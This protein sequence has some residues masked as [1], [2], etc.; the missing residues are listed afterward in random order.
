MFYEELI[1]VDVWGP[2][3]KGCLSSVVDLQRLV[4]YCSSKKQSLL[5]L[6]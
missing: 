3:Q 1:T 2:E 5:H 6:G 4:K